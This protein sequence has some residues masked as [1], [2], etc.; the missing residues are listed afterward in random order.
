LVVTVR[1]DPI[2]RLGQ[3]LADERAVAEQAAALGVFLVGC[4]M[5]RLSPLHEP[6][7]ITGGAI[8]VGGVVLGI[9]L[10]VGWAKH[11]DA[12]DC[13]DDAILSGFLTTAQDTPVQRAVSHRVVSIEKP[14]SRRRL[15]S[16]LRWRLKLA[17]GTAHPSPGYMR[18]SVL[19]PLSPSERCV[20]V[21]ERC[22]VLDLADRL[23]HAPVEPQALVILWRIVTTPPRL[24][25]DGDR[26]A[27]EELRRRLRAASRLITSGDLAEGAQDD[28]AP[29]DRLT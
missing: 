22:L 14:R 16:G 5:W 12:V 25:R 19:P 28:A 29:A 7:P 13:A 17:D 27:G 24:D 23:E 6:E 9:V 18:A 3:A 26:V 15:A 4:A 1:D 2:F 21:D 20:L 11:E 8:A 10:L